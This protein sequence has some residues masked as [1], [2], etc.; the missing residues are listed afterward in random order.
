MTAG[1][2]PLGGRVVATAGAGAFA[3]TC[4]GVGGARGMFSVP[5]AVVVRTG[6]VGVTRIGGGGISEASGLLDRDPG[7]TASSAVLRST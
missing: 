5:G 4:S 2:S 7:R 3:W 1:C 6:V